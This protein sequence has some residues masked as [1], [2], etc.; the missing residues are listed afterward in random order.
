MFNNNTTSSGAPGLFGN[1]TTGA[2]TGGL[3]SSNN[4]ATT[5][6]APATG[7]AT[8]GSNLFSGGTFE[9]IRCNRRCGYH[10][11]VLKHTNW[12]TSD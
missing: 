7:Q 10:R 3:F 5:N 2:T 1:N 12:T 11:N 9:V 6:P 4:A 8:G